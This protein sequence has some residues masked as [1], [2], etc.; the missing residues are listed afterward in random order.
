MCAFKVLQFNMQF[1]QNWNEANPD[2]APIIAKYRMITNA[3]AASTPTATSAAAV[4]ATNK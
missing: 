4:P 2:F 3:A 1:G